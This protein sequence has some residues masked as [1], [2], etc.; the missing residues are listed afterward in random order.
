MRSR[1]FSLLLNVLLAAF[2][3]RVDAAP[4]SQDAS[5][6]NRFALAGLQGNAFA[7]AFDKHRT[8]L[9]GAMQS[10]GRVLAEAVVEREGNDWRALTNG[11]EAGP[12]S[13]NV[14]TMDVFKGTL[15]VGG[16]FKS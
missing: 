16:F 4:R 9:G 11:P 15:Y 12:L 7:M 6:D 3:F 2:V 10:I 8:Y 14:L 1:D 5:W 13:L